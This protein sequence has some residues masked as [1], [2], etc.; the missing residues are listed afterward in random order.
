MRSFRRKR[1]AGNRAMTAE[2]SA[3]VEDAKDCCCI[4]CHVWSTAGH[5]P[6]AHIATQSAWDHKKSGNIRR[7]HRK[8]F[9]NCDWH[10]QA[11]VPD[12]WTHARMR[13]HFG[14]SLMDG[15]KLFAR[16]YGSDDELIALQ[17]ELLGR[18]EAA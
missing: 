15:S 5:M 1:R 18:K 7:G 16:T 14:P 11:I 13:A 2:E 4:P 6:A 12:G 17:L 3:L 8:G 10:H 9:A